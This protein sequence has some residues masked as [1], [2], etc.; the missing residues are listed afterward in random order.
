M[1]DPEPNRRDEA[2]PAVEP[3]SPRVG[4]QAGRPLRW[5]ACVDSARGVRAPRDPKVRCAS[6]AIASG[7]SSA[8]NLRAGYDCPGCGRARVGNSRF[9]W[10]R[11]HI[12]L[13][14]FGR[15][16]W[17]PD[18]LQRGLQVEF[19]VECVAAIALRG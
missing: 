11:G 13:L 3:L 6:V 2:G 16:T 1:T 17:T 7:P 4:G 8:R 10:P 12:R 9:G 14:D 18:A 15:P 19:D 5:L